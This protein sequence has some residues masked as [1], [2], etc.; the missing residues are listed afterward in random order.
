MSNSKIFKFEE[1]DPRII[2]Y[3]LREMAHRG[4]DVETTIYNVEEGNH[5]IST[6]INRAQDWSDGK[7]N[8]YVSDI[9][10][11]AKRELLSLKK[12]NWIKE[13]KLACFFFWLSIAYSEKL[14]ASPAHPFED[15]DRSLHRHSQNRPRSL[16]FTYENLNLSSSLSNSQERFDEIVKFL[17][18][19]EQ[20]L[21]WQH[22]L[23]EQLKQD[24]IY[25]CDDRKYFAWLNKDNDEQCRWGL[26]YIHS[27][28][29]NEDLHDVPSTYGIQ[30][31]NTGERYLLI[32]AT[33]HC[34]RSS[35]EA[36]KLFSHNF[37]KAWNQKKVRDKR[38]SVGKKSIAIIISEDV[39]NRLD[40]M[41]SN[42]GHKRDK[43]I[44][45]LIEKEYSN[46]IESKE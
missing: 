13:D 22:Q 1:K 27:Y 19:T 39:K 18:R 6:A 29:R 25:I 40:E 21:D 24:W 36:K 33:F 2:E 5:R 42:Q 41:I 14:L 8:Q 26:D 12:L 16:G 9:L 17:D 10:D 4:F 38:E 3:C 7:K 45:M 43:F 44:E 37:N 11:A 23:I 34:W 20:P 31:V 15:I 30:A 35:K 32:Y 28:G 46:T